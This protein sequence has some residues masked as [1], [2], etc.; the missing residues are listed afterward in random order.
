VTLLLLITL[1]LMSAVVGFMLREALY[2]SGVYRFIS[3]W[4]PL[5]LLTHNAYHAGYR[6]GVAVS[7]DLAIDR[8]D[9]DD[10]DTYT[11]LLAAEHNLAEDSE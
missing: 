7:L 6:E 4:R 3:T 10:L 9:L 5:E 11:D 1:A 8:F 2:R